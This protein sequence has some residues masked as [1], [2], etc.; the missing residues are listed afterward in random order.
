ML[1][2][3][4]PFAIVEDAT[5]IGL[6]ESLA[7]PTAKAEDFS[8]YRLHKASSVPIGLRSNSVAALPTSSWT[9]VMSKVAERVEISLTE[10][11]VPW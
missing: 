5:Y 7:V 1:A 2:K 3:M 10:P 8:K 11:V 6:L 9:P 4:T